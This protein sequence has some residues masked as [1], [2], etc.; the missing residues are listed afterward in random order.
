M[1]RNSIG[2]L[3]KQVNFG[4]SS[5]IVALSLRAVFGFVFFFLGAILGLW[6]K[7]KME[8][9]VDVKRRRWKR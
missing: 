3:P 2:S 6:M 1:Y 5:S 7:M 9:E 8:V 4:D